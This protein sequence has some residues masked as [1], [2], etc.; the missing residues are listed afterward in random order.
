MIGYSLQLLPR[1]IV[2]MVKKDPTIHVFLINM[3]MIFL[4]TFQSSLS[5]WERWVLVWSRSRLITTKKAV[6]FLEFY[7]P[8]ELYCV[9]LFSSVGRILFM[10]GKVQFEIQK[11]LDTYV[12]KAVWCKTQTRKF[13]L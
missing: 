12:S 6:S 9:T 8:Y 1:P 13:C 11:L 2:L 4:T 5:R 3:G 7:F 10:C